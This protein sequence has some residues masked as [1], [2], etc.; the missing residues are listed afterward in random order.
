MDFKPQS[1]AEMKSSVWVQNA[2]SS[3]FDVPYIWSEGEKP[4]L[5]STCTLLPLLKH[6]TGVPQG[7][8]HRLEM[9]PTKSQ[10]IPAVNDSGVFPPWHFMHRDF[11]SFQ[12]QW[13]SSQRPWFLQNGECHTWVLSAYLAA[14]QLHEVTEL[15]QG[16]LDRI[17]KQAPAR[18]LTLLP[19]WRSQIA[20]ALQSDQT[21]ERRPLTCAAALSLTRWQSVWKWAVITMCPISCIL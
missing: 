1:A 10:Q 18:P 21:V 13:P 5:P 8:V 12:S 2:R 16:S 4:L 11:H 19:L 3:A 7:T 14:K 20:P 9:F 17:G 6:L 15:F